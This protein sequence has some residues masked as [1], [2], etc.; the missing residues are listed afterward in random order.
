M[1]GGEAGEQARQLAYW[2]AQLGDEHPV[3]QLPGD[4]P[5]QG[6][7]NYQ[8]AHHPIELAA[9]IAAGLQQTAR[10]H[11]VTL[12]MVLLA[13][14][15]VL[16]HRYTGQEDIRVGTNNAN[17]HRPQTQNVVGLFVN[18]QVLRSQVEAECRSTRC[19]GKFDGWC[20]EHKSTRICPLSNWWRRCSRSAASPHPPLFQV[21]MNHQRVDY[22]GLDQ[23]PGL[24]LQP[25]ELGEQA[26]KFELLLSTVEHPEG[27]ITLALS[28]AA[29]LF[30]AAD[31]GAAG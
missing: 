28:Y 8:I 18:A 17:R 29:E 10:D 6:K 19:W 1:S 21:L 11:Q 13:G 12:F 30:D 7:A 24:T 25:Y 26:A 2:R 4:H 3:L 5:P 27:R 23:L 20:W 14:F 15:Q 9:S 22:R 16:L 31:D